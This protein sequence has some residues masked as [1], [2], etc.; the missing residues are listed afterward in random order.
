MKEVSVLIL[1]QNAALRVTVNPL[2]AELHSVLLD[3]R[4]RLW[5]G[6]PQIWSG[7]APV[8]FP[9][10]GAFLDNRYTHEGVAYEMPQHGF[11]RRRLFR[12]AEQSESAVSLTLDTPER[13]YPFPYRLTVRFELSGSAIR[14]CYRVD[15]PGSGA[16][17]Y[18]LGAHEAYACPEGIEHCR[19]IFEQDDV[20]HRGILAGAQLTHET[21]T[22]TLTGRALP[23]RADMF[24][25]DALVFAA[26]RSRSVTL[27]NDVN[28]HAVRV[29]Y[30]DYPTLLLWQ[31][32]GAKYLCIEPW[33]NPPEFCDHDGLLVHK[34]GVQRLE[35][36]EG[37]DY[38]HTITFA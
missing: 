18:C 32:P 34:P 10:A 21:E 8:L 13:N 15:N 6:D 33:T 3:G 25:P 4:E 11:A 29:D 30:P 9:V 28:S 5:Q 7:R 22:L 35:A 38:I 24:I 12:V 19:V 36:G 14:V 1:L 26:L 17:Y 16:L 31:K 23:L 20:L 37:R 27:K 2:G